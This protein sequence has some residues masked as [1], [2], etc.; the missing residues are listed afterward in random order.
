P[1][2]PRGWGRRRPP[3]PLL[4]A[5]DVDQDEELSA[6]EIDGATAALLTLDQNGD[7]NLTLEELRPPREGRPGRGFGGPPDMGRM[8][9]IV[10]ALDKDRDAELFD[11]EVTDATISLRKLD[12]DGDGM[13][14]A[15]ELRPR[16]GRGGPPGGRRRGGFGGPGGFGGDEPR[17]GGALEPTELDPEDGA[18]EIPDRAKFVELS[19]Q[20][21]E[22]MIDTHLAGLE[23]VKFQIEGAGTENP[24]IYFMNTKT[25]R[26][27]PMFMSKIGLDQRAE[28][29]MRGVL[30][31]WPLLE[32]PSGETGLYTYEF[33]PNDAF[34]FEMIQVAHQLLGK[35]SALLRGRIAYN[36][37][38]RAKEKYLTETEKY[39]A[40]KIPVF[41]TADRFASIRYLP[42][43][44]GESFGRLR[45]MGATDL[46]GPRDIVLCTALPNEMPRVAGVISA[47][48]Q[49]PLSHVN[50]RAIQ[51]DI[52]NAYIS[53]AAEKK[54]IIDLVGKAVY[55]RVSADGYAIRE[56]TPEEVDAHF[57]DLRPAEPRTPIRDLT[58]RKIRPLSE[59]AFGDSASVGVKAANLGV[60]RSIGLPEEATPQGFA[61][62]FSF[63]VEFMEHNGFFDMAAKMMATP[64]FVSNAVTR[65]ESLK[66]FRKAIK[67]GKMPSW[68]MDAL[69]EV[70]KQFPEGTSIRARSSTNNEDLP[71]F[72]GAGLY[73]SYTHH[74][75]EGHLSK[76]V[77]QVF[78]S[79]WNFRAFEEREFYRVDHLATA[80][81]V[82]L[83]SNTEGERANGVAVTRDILYRTEEQGP[84]FYVNAQAGEDLVTNPTEGSS[85]EELLIGPRN[86][87][88]DQWIR[89]SSA[90][91]EGQSLLDAGQLLELRRTLRRIHERFRELYGVSL[92]ETEFAMEVE[93]KITDAGRLFIKQARP[94][95]FH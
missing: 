74:P 12:R 32:A 30:V 27:H 35:H 10:A 22:V 15:E 58:V 55:Y 82:A 73:D 7:G 34:P 48:R 45:V 14:S 54:A 84:R 50:L 5:L 47:V 33:E 9:P 29:R 39:E 81:G 42:L 3:S 95:V 90:K 68:M 2:E 26:A 11:D 25:H 8:D 38:T 67:K 75:D 91:G 46:P 85:P 17:E 52:P 72:S 43:H 37:L 62:P 36:L 78:A 61:I 86:P 53:G 13:L 65:E 19:Y 70:Q 64:D 16:F 59:I 20:G 56:A 6:E 24:K 49:T 21:E 23:F 92:D 79:L 66:E 88:S 40:A 71:G 1:G 51:D 94:W 44:E 31:Y 4:S 83:H 93:F 28:G 69:T 80:M 18:A 41:E 63:Y 77:K 57:A 76:T 60:L 89:Y 87:R